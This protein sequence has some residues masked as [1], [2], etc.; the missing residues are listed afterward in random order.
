MPD[1]LLGR[2]TLAALWVCVFCL[3]VG[4]SARGE[5]WPFWRGPNR[6]GVSHEKGIPATWSATENVAWRL[7][8]PGPA[9]ATPIV[10][11]DSVFL[12]S[13]DG[14]KLVLL[15]VGTDGRPRWRRVVGWGNRDVRGDEGNSA[16][17]SPSTDGEHVW[18]FFTSGDLACYDFQGNRVWH[19]NL[20]DR[21][22]RFEI[23]FG[24]TS[25]P[26]LD[27]DRLYLQLIHSG[28]AKVLALD[29]GSGREVWLVKRPSDAIAECEQAYASPQLYRD[30]QRAFLLTHG[31]DYI[32]AHDLDDGREIWR[33]GGL[34]PAS[35]YD[36][37]LRFVSSPL[38]VPGLIV[39]PSAKRGPTLALKPGGSGDITG[40]DEFYYWKY[41]LTPD[42]PSPLAVGGLV[43]LCRQNGNLICLDAKTG[44]QQYQQ[45]TYPHRHRASPV[46]A[47]GKIFL[48]ARDGRITVCKPGREFAIL[49]VNEMGEPMSAS[50]VVSGGRLYLRTFEALYAIGNASGR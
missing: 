6:D 34:H 48:T 13:V 33:C 30:D 43:Y 41:K 12:T 45:R 1:R 5:N 26:I 31:A 24:M 22:G 44:Q 39:V 11:N 25:T 50:P 8:L 28:G 7:P 38:A 9:G 29:K 4:G 10:W 35:G 15:C 20:Q 16:S 36:P 17:P 2:R 32:V 49:A 14:D 21:Y 3:A 40:R 19:V 37:T 42:V 47:D 18:A 46:Y 27:G 23:A